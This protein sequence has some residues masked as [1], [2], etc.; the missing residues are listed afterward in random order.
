MPS[1]QQTMCITCASQNALT[2]VSL[3]EIVVYYL[4]DQLINV[5][6]VS[7]CLAILHAHYLQAFLF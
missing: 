7:E 1:L 6:N 3:S 4:E 5:Q 2:S